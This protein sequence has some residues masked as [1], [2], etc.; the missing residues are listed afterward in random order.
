[1]S[2]FSTVIMI[3]SWVY[4]LWRSPWDHP[5]F[6]TR[7]RSIASIIWH[8]QSTPGPN[9][10]TIAAILAISSHLPT[11]SISKPHSWTPILSL[12]R[13]PGSL[14]H[15]DAP[16]VLVSD[17]RGDRGG[18]PGSAGPVQGYTHLL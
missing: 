3:H 5:V 1:I 2:T 16:A 13:A 14:W 7:L 9:P 15:Q 4:G 11:A 10:P 6:A 8:S 18:M 12:P 17:C